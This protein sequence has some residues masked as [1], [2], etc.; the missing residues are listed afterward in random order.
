MFIPDFQHL[1]DNARLWVYAANRPINLEEHEYI[2]GRL[3]N[4]IDDWQ[5]HGAKLKAAF[6]LLHRRFILIAVDEG[7]QNATGCS[8]DA[9][10]HEI[11]DIGQSLGLDF[12]NRMQVVYRDETNNLVVSCSIAE[13]KALIA[14]HDFPDDTPI[15][16]TGITHLSDLNTNWEIPA[17]QSWVNRY[18]NAVKA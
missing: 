7:P 14:G 16:N 3:S 17:Y 2:C 11:Q 6:T 8:I 15:F 9:C 12:F 10:V 13:L 5:A 1:P 18:L 4:F